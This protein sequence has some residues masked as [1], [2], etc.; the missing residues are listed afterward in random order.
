[1]KFPGLRALCPVLVLF[2]FSLNAAAEVNLRASPLAPLIGGVMLEADFKISDKWSLGPALTYIS[3]DRDGFETKAYSIGARGNYFF[4]GTFKQGWYL[5]PG[6]SYVAAT[7][8]DD[9]STFG[10]IEGKSSG[11]AINIFGGYLWMWENFNIMLGAG[12]VIYTLGG[13]T[14]ENNSQNYKEDYEGYDGVDLGLDFTLG[15]KF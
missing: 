3:A 4:E 13:I 1:M 6:V 12:P 2:C 11:L 5:S 9:D 15:W 8:K 14:V 7:V 10:D